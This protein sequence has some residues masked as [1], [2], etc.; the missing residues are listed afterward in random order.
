VEPR[1]LG[2]CGVG[3]RSRAQGAFGTTPA[4]LL[5]GNKS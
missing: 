3:R 2:C 5:G 4:F 1:M